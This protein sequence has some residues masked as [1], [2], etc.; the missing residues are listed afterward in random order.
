MVLFLQVS[1]AAELRAIKGK[2]SKLNM[3]I[4]E[5]LMRFLIFGIFRDL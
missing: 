1:S 2:I 3:T 4:G 5:M